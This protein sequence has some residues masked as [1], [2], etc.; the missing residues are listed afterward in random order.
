MLFYKARFFTV[1]V[2]KKIDYSS[3]MRMRIEQIF[4][5]INYAIV[6]LHVYD[7]Q[8]NKIRSFVTQKIPRILQKSFIV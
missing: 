8:P 2:I 6:F 1:D 5:S 3:M 4:L 7:I